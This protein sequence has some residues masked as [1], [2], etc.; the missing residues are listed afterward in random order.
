LKTLLESDALRAELPGWALR[1]VLCAASSAAQPALMGF[2]HPME[3]AGMV[4]GVG[5]WVIVFAAWCAWR[6]N[7]SHWNQSQAVVALKWAAWIKI[8]LT[9]TGWALFALGGMMKFE[10]LSQMGMLGMVDTLLGLASLA[11]VAW[12]AGL[13]GPEMVAAADSFEWT[14]LTTVIEGFLMALV[15]VGIALCVWCGW[16]AWAGLGLRG[17]FPPARRVG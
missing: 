11:F 7:I 8:G 17:N 10:A 16:R 12:I 5:F 14:A 15:I 9:A 2:Q 6:P 3:I 13:K 1:G 4:A